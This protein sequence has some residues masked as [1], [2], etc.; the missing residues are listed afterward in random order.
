[1]AY[2]LVW[3]AEAEDDLKAIV[4]YLKRNW[5]IQSAE[6]FIFYTYKRLE[7]LT[8]MPSVAH[9]TSQ[10]EVYMYKLDKKM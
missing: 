3:T 1:M 6:K 4:L 5:S 10:S 8:V 2:E 7:K 9:P